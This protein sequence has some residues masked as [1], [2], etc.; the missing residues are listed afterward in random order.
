VP[1][2]PEHK[3]LQLEFFDDSVDGSN[4]CIE[5]TVGRTDC[6]R[7]LRNR[8]G[9]RE[10][11]TRARPEHPRGYIVPVALHRAVASAVCTGRLTVMEQRV[12][13]FAQL[14]H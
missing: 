7:Y 10:S 9:L 4:F 1:L 3:R 13:C 14:L 2:S 6:R 5:F 11:E 12:L 8:T